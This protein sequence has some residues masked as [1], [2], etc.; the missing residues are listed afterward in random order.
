MDSGFRLAAHAP[1]LGRLIQRDPAGFPD[2]PNRYTYAGGN[3]VNFIDPSGL[4][5]RSWL[6]RQA[7]RA[8][9]L[10]AGFGDSVTFGL[11]RRARQALGVDDQIDKCS[12][13][14]RAGAAIDEYSGY[15]NPVAGLAR[16]GLK[17]GH[18]RALKKCRTSFVAGT[19]VATPDGLVPIEPSSPAVFTDLLQGEVE[20]LIASTSMTGPITRAASRRY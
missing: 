1:E 11:T 10:A 7:E 8:G 3:P 2:G 17:R 5:W 15:I 13:W 14:Y 12:G 16:R 6:Y 18:K 20:Q 4:G 19:P 9:N